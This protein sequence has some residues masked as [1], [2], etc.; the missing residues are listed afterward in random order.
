MKIKE[1]WIQ[2][3]GPLPNRGEIKLSDFN[4]IYGMNEVGKTLTIEALIRLLLGKTSKKFSKIDRVE[5]EPEGYIII[6]TE[7]GDKKIGREIRLSDIVDLTMSECRNIFIIRNSDLS[8]EEESDF[9]TEITDRLTGL[10]TKKIEKLKEKI[11]DIAKITPKYFFFD[12]KED[13]NLKSRMVKAKSLLEEIEPLKKEVEKEGLDQLEK[14]WIKLSNEIKTKEKLE[15]KYDDARRREKFE[16]GNKALELRNKK[17]KEKEKLEKFTREDYQKW[18]D[19]EKSIQLLGKEEM[20][21]KN[22]LEKKEER[23]R[24]LEEGIKEKEI[25][26]DTLKE[27]NKIVDECK[28]QVEDLKGRKVKIIGDEESILLENRWLWVF[29]SLAIL[30][31]IGLIFHPSIFIFSF[32]TLVFSTIFFFFFILRWRIKKR[33]SKYVK[34]LSKIEMKLASS[35]LKALTIQDL[36]REIEEFNRQ[37]KKKEAYLNEEKMSRI[38]LKESIQEKSSKK[39]PEIENKIQNNKEIIQGIKDSSL[40]KDLKEYERKLK[41]REECERII[42]EEERALEELFP[43]GSWEEKIEEIS[44]YANKATSLVYSE[45]E[46]KKLGEEL[47]STQERLNELENKIGN[48]EEKFKEIERKSNE[49]LLDKDIRCDGTNDLKIVKNEI[50]EFIDLNEKRKE[51]AKIATEILDEIN[52]EERSKIAEQFGEESSVSNYFSWITEGLYKR[53]D[54]DGESGMIKV[55]MKD[56]MSLPAWKLSGGAYDQLYLSIRL[57]LGEKLL[58]DKKGFFIMDDPFIKA[59]PERLEREIETLR[60]ICKSGW[61]IIYFSAKGEIKEALKK[62]IQK[63]TLNFIQLPKIF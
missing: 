16:K 21:E 44:N 4:L 43:G 33:K 35:G 56:G 3:Y 10:E 19:A 8:I 1:F 32:L 49:V 13:N 14:K 18:R 59:S 37:Y 11:L 12:R 5:E 46:Y 9:Y 60:N 25:E 31:I 27:K 23:L 63:K 41:E 50:V 34:D 30:S 62:D 39:I 40:S 20:D 36:I 47:D 48:F 15:K 57:A 22:E 45:N 52:K 61:Q 2:R 38:S 6:N 7:E 51:D 28:L 53:V 17:L 55:M 26:F 29:S 58:S 42:G 24:I 54:F